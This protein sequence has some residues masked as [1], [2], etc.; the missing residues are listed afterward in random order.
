MTDVFTELTNSNS[1]ELIY[2]IINI[3]EKVAKNLQ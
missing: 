1:E 2:N 3:F